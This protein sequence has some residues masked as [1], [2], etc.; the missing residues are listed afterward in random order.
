MTCI[1]GLF[2][3]SSGRLRVLRLLL[4]SLLIG[5]LSPAVNASLAM[6]RAG[7]GQDICSASPLW[8]SLGDRADGTDSPFDAAGEHGQ[9]HC[10]FC[11]LPADAVAGLPPL[12]GWVVAD[13]V[14]RPAVPFTSEPARPRLDA[15]PA[16]LSRAPPRRD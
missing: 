10:L 1:T 11:R 8:S 15:W 5:V 13:G 2:P 9:G 4:L 3:G 14:V 16:S 7:P 12:G 6:D